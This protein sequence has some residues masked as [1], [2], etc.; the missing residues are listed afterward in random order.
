MYGFDRI[1]REI[2]TKW[3]ARRNLSVLT[4]ADAADFGVTGAELTAA[5]DQRA[6]VFERVTRMSEVY[7]AGPAL[8]TAGRYALFEMA[9]TC[10]RCPHERDCARKLYGRLRPRVKD[11]DFCPNAADYAALTLESNAAH[12]S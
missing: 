2:R 6:D 9:R 3:A 12:A 11:V 1:V 10:D 8:K 5:A 7:G 4:L